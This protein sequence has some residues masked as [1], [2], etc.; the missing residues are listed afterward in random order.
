MTMQVIQHIEL[1]SSA[2]SITFSSIP[3]TY[4]DLYLVVSARSSRSNNSFYTN[5]KIGINGLTSGYS[6][7]DLIGQ[8]DGSSSIVESRTGLTDSLWSYTF[9]SS[10]S[11]SNTFGN[12]TFYFPNY[13]GST[14][15]TVAVD[16][17][18]EHNAQ[19]QYSWL[20]G[21]LAG[22][23]TTTSAITSIELGIR[24]ADSANYLSGSSATLY[25]ITKGSDGT[26]TVS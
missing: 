3:Q 8:F 18:S 22:L 9:P 25:G 7:R 4:T 12:T 16:M 26:T 13:S 10:V 23:N 17:T 1:G 15:K 24:T 5:G 6:L 19:A 21:I 2:S 14:S 20:L 11:T